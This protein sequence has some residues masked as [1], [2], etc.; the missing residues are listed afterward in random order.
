MVILRSPYVA[1]A[2]QGRLR[3]RKDLMRIRKHE[4]LSRAGA[5]R[6]T[7]SSGVVVTA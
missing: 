4:I 7:L 3:D 6:M 5:L 2:P 1:V